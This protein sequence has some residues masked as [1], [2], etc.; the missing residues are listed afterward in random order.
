MELREI[1][2]VQRAVLVA[3]AFA[4]IYSLAIQDDGSTVRANGSE[5]R[6]YR[7][8]VQ[9]HG[10]MVAFED[11]TTRADGNDEIVAFNTES[12]KYHC[13]DCRWAIACTRNC[14]KIPIAEARKRRGV[15]CKV[16]R[17]S[18]DLRRFR[19]TPY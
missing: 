18:C 9:G 6:E 7:P 10:S 1:V 5:A 19:S 12:R 13:L 8:E 2:A 14:I 17:G 15:P 11:S 3:L 4:F 16:C